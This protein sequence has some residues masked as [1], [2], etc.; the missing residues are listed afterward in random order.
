MPVYIHQPDALAL[1]AKL[2]GEEWLA[3]QR[4]RTASEYHF[5]IW[6]AAW[7]LKVAAGHEHEDHPLSEYI[8]DQFQFP[9]SPII[10]GKGGF[11]RYI[12]LHDGEIAFSRM[13]SIARRIPEAAALG[14]T[15][16]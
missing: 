15:L 8:E 5:P 9:V 4:L 12:V 3:E 1:M 13:H 6:L 11:H 16:G 7:N 10:Y 2:E 14:F